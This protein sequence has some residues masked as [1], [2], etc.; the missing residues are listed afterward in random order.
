MQLLD[1]R[2]LLG[3]F[4]ACMPQKLCQETTNSQGKSSRGRQHVGPTPS[5]QRTGV[6]SGSA[7]STP[8]LDANLAG[9]FLPILPL[10][11][12]SPGELLPST[13]VVLHLLG[14]KFSR[15]FQAAA[16]MKTAYVLG[17]PQP[18][19][20]QSHHPQLN[21]FQP[22]IHSFSWETGNGK[23]GTAERVSHSAKRSRH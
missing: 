11:A 3:R 4:C 19:N 1:R 12:P 15:A 16:R 20:R 10:L 6:G 8:H 5:R 14:C 22:L 18:I 2:V 21:F 9:F 17:F 7:S 13:K 23:R